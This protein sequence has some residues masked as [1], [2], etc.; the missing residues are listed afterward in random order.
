[1]KEIIESRVLEGVMAGLDSGAIPPGDSQ[2]RNILNFSYNCL[3]EKVRKRHDK[4]NK[5]I[6]ALAAIRES[7]R[8]AEEEAW[9]KRH[10]ELQT[11]IQAEE[12]KEYIDC[13]VAEAAPIKS[14][15]VYVLFAKNG[16]LTIGDVNEALRGW[17]VDPFNDRKGMPLKNFAAGKY[18]CLSQDGVHMVRITTD[19]PDLISYLGIHEKGT[20]TIARRESHKPALLSSSPCP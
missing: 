16:R 11:A 2:Y 13:L 10:P 5:I 4:N 3:P 14:G 7:E 20:V 1:M 17:G 18:I 6:K 15:K 19:R 12:S 8:I 9:K